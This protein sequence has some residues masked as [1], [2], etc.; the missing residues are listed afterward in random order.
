MRSLLRIH[1]IY[2]RETYE[3][4]DIPEGAFRD[5]E[6]SVATYPI[7]LG[8]A[9]INEPDLLSRHRAITAAAWRIEM[10][11]PRTFMESYR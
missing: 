7:R 6:A 3:M 5:I 2:N 9:G 4:R 8:R 11:T 1:T 10:I